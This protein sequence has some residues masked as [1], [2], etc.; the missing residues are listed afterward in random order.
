MPGRE[1]RRKTVT[2]LYLAMGAQSEDHSD[3]DEDRSADR[4]RPERVKKESLIF[5]VWMK[6]D[7]FVEREDRE[8]TEEI[9][10]AI[11]DKIPPPQGEP[12]KPLRA[13]IFDSKFDSYQGVVAYFRIIDGKFRTHDQ[14]LMMQTRAPA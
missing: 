7:H 3:R 11:I 2:N 8:G 9:L 12:E 13:L 1:S 5:W 4:R 6:R 10:T 14:V